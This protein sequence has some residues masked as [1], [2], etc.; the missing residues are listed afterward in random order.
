MQVPVDRAAGVRDWTL[1]DLRRTTAARMAG[2]ATPPQIVLALLNHRP[3]V[4]VRTYQVADREDEKRAAWERWAGHV[5]AIV[6]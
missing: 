2:T 3:P 6:G 5:A 1:H 4:L